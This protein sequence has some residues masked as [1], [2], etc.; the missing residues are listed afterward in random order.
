[1]RGKAQI[2]DPAFS[3]KGVRRG[4]ECRVLVFWVW[5]CRYELCDFE[6]GDPLL[7]ALMCSPVSRMKQPLSKGVVMASGDRAKVLC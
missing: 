4:G 2:T 6:E 3:Q 1:M 5:L 7:W